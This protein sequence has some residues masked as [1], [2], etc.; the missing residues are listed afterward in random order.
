MTIVTHSLCISGDVFR[1]S[2]SEI[3]C[4]S[5]DSEECPRTVVIQ[6]NGMDFNS[7]STYTYGP[8]PTFSSVTPD[9]IIP[10]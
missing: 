5:Q 10:A 3:Q 2:P 8:D 4:T 6:V 9:K 7:D 1:F